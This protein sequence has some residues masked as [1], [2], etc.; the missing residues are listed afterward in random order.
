MIVWHTSSWYRKID[1]RANYWPCEKLGTLR[2]LTQYRNIFFFFAF[3][4]KAGLGRRAIIRVLHVYNKVK[5][6]RRHFIRR[7]PTYYRDMHW[8]SQC[9]FSFSASSTNFRMVDKVWVNGRQ[10]EVS[11]TC[12]PKFLFLT[13]S[14]QA[15][16]R[17]V[18]GDTHSELALIGIK[19]SPAALF[20]VLQTC[21][22]LVTREC[23]H[24][25]QWEG[26]PERDARFLWRVLEPCHVSGSAVMVSTSTRILIRTH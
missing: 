11:L 18:W 8:T 7:A 25:W 17:R 26:Y 20:A 12:H 22:P 19:L 24:R 21:Y 23:Y 1:R 13:E 15:Q 9:L 5:M 3:F 4:I 10:L 16:L 14:C 6:R 2:R